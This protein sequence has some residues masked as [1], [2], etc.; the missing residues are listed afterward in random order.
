LDFTNR[1]VIKIT[2]NGT[3][4]GS[5][6]NFVSSSANN[7][8]RIYLAN[9]RSSN[10]YK[11]NVSIDNFEIGELVPTAATITGVA[12]LMTL[13]DAGATANYTFNAYQPALG[14][15]VSFV[16]ATSD[17]DWEISDYNGISTDLVSITR[18]ANYTQAI[19][20]TNNAVSTNT[21]IT[22]KATFATQEATKTVT[23][24]PVDVSALKADLLAEI[25]LASALDDDVITDGIPYLTTI[26]NDLTSA[27][28]T[29]QGVYDN[30][31]ATALQINNAIL[32]L[33]S[34]ENTFSTALA[35]YNALV[36]LIT[37]AQTAHNDET[38]TSATVVAA[39]AALQT[40][41]DVA[42]AACST[43]SS[44]EDIADATAALQAALTAFN[45][46]ISYTEIAAFEGS[47]LFNSYAVD[48]SQDDHMKSTIV[49]NPL[50]ACLNSSAKSLKITST[51][52]KDN[53]YE[54]VLLKNSN[55]TPVTITAQ[56][57]Y[58]HIMIYSATSN[59]VNFRFKKTSGES[60]DD[61]KDAGNN[62]ATFS[63]GEWKDLVIDLSTAQGGAVSNLYGI[64]VSGHWDIDNATYYL[65]DIVINNSATPRTCVPFI[66]DAPKTSSEYLGGYYNDIIF[67]DGGQLTIDQT[68]NTGGLKPYGVIK[69][70]KTFDEGKWSSIGFPFAINEVRC[71][72]LVAANS[73]W[74]PV[75]LPY[76]STPYGEDYYGDFWL[77][78][79]DYEKGF[80]YTE[81]M[82][83]GNGYIIQFYEWYAGKKITF[84][85]SGDALLPSV[86]NLS[87]TNNYRLIAN[88]GSNNLT[89][90]APDNDKYYYILDSDSEGNSEYDRLINNDAI[91]PPFE[92]IIAIEE[93]EASNLLYSINIANEITAIKPVPAIH[94][95]PVTATHYYTLQGFEVRK[96]AENGIYL[97]K[98]VHR[99][100]KEE[101]IKIYNSK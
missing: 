90:N 91:I 12:E 14:I 20:K 11:P 98:K 19:L 101:I 55:N 75:L 95:D 69:V 47:D 96:P 51:S 29:A 49:D 64:F 3:E 70:N 50:S 1:K 46:A 84:V 23:L 83:A 39:K 87:I 88:P 61:I 67:E 28:S 71:E 9:T 45:D 5:D 33:Q 93:A 89:L 44:S 82:E 18:D 100:G 26:V 21:D 15:D 27:I 24:K 60:F 31:E 94:D 56:S 53:W 6:L 7:T 2:I 79:Y 36:T 80:S 8:S 17:I 38:R 74:S 22:L 43:V 41:I 99:S 34:A 68:N 66:V 57:K 78:S 37:T 92:A 13:E 81:E 58:L 42:N 86:S 25:A 65:D 52:A 48:W 4:I 16:N 59:K 76:R 72:D 77:K 85:S 10:N 30:S 32:A 40:A 62:A 73:E 54:R 97:V 35:N 63:T